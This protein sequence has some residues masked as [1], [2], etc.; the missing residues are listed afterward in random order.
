M[1]EREIKSLNKWHRHK[2]Q[3]VNGSVLMRKEAHDRL[4]AGFRGF[5]ARTSTSKWFR[6]GEGDDIIAD[7][8]QRESK[9]GVTTMT[10][11]EEA[12]PQTHFTRRMH[13]RNKPNSLVV[14][15]LVLDASSQLN[16]LKIGLLLFV[17]PGSR[18]TQV[19][20]RVLCVSELQGGDWRQR[21]LRLSWTIKTLLVRCP[22]R[23]F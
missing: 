16:P 1:R 6:P 9:A 4:W 15:I 18:R 17:V 10:Q 12:A 7:S 2:F 20:P 22:H 21:Y 3:K 23:S 19:S 11:W 5:K 14:D 13:G 8:R